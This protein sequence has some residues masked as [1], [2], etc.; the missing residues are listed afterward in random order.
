M[1]LQVMT[2]SSN[3]CT[4]HNTEFHLL[5]YRD[6]QYF[7]GQQKFRRNMSSP[8]WRSK[9]KPGKKKNSLKREASRTDLEDSGDTFLR[10]VA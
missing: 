4:A 2:P 5:G 8:S 3:S 9:N 6:V 7:R 10:N 1:V